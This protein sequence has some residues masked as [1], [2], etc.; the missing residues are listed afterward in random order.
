MPV[1]TQCAH[2]RVRACVFCSD[3]ARALGIEYCS[4]DEVISQSDILSLHLPLLPDTYHIIGK[5]TLAKMKKGVVI[6][7]V[8]RGGLVDASAV[9]DALK[10]GA[11]SFN[12]VLC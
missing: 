2:V 6:I 4:L 1:R 10:S 5:E 11:Q 3:E 12:F 7:N 9:Q 8:S